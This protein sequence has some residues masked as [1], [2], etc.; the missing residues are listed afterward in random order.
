MKIFHNSL[1]TSAKTLALV[2]RAEA[3]HLPLSG[4]GQLSRALL[5][6]VHDPAYVAARL[7][8]QGEAAEGIMDAAGPLVAAAHYSIVTGRTGVAPCYGGAAGWN[9]GSDTDPFN[10][11][12]AVCAIARQHRQH[13][14]VLDCN[15]AV[16]GLESCLRNAGLS[17]W[18][19][20]YEVAR[21]FRYP[22][23]ARVFLDGLPALLEQVCHSCP[24]LL[25][26]AGCGALREGDAGWMTPQQITERD[27]T[28]LRHARHLGRTLIVCTGDGFNPPGLTLDIQTNLLRKI[29][30]TVDSR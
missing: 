21:W 22:N 11:V 16:S 28:V 25:Y 6:Q 10:G 19:N 23:A 17:H 4:A 8:L 30:E 27:E 2:G 15:A 1:S 13:I 7:E 26:I 5:E 9:Y 29:V 12:A 24:T 18:V 14:A 3:M 20:A